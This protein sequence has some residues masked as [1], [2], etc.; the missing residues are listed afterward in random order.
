MRLRQHQIGGGPEP[1]EYPR[2]AWLSHKAGQPC[3]PLNTTM[4]RQAEGR[5]KERAAILGRRRILSIWD[6]LAF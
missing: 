5:E 4:N 6:F 2:K 1:H 3:F